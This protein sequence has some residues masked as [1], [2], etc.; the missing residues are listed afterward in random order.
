MVLCFYHLFSIEVVWGLHEVDSL[1]LLSLLLKMK[2]I[3]WKALPKCRLALSQT[4]LVHSDYD[5]EQFERSY[6]S[7]CWSLLDLSL[8]L[9]P[10]KICQG[11]VGFS[12]PILIQGEWVIKKAI[13]P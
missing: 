9:T 8:T 13:C 7:R 12:A 4:C 6:T 3:K 5:E 1:Y 10:S 11:R 2:G